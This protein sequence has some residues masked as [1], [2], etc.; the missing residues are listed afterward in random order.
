MVVGELFLGAFITVVIEK[1]ASG[2][3]IRLAQSA[4]IYSELDKWNQ[5]SAQIQAVLVDAGEKHLRQTSVELWLNKL[6]HLV[7]DIDDV[8]DDLTTEA[9]RRH[10]SQRSSAST[11]TSEVFNIIPTKFQAFKYGRNMGSK[12]DMITT[13]LHH[14]V[15]EKNF[16]G[17]SDDVRR[18]NTKIKRLEET[19]LV[20]VSTI[21]GR[22]G[23]KELLL[24]KLLGNE[25]CSWSGWIGKTTLAQVLYNDTKVKDHFELKS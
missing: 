5:K 22:K 21:V 25:S 9:T 24:G 10:K 14:L 2:D 15:E 12:L 6:K 20:N 1:L 3:L 17:L 16:L 13:K 19:S 11:S 4:G 7:Y 23:D 8:L 18:P